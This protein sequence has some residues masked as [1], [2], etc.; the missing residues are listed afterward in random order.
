MST[1]FKSIVV[2]A[3][4]YLLISF[5]FSTF[6]LKCYAQGDFEKPPIDYLNAPVNDSVHRL[7]ELTQ[8]GEL[9]LD[10]D[11]EF[12]YLK[13]V[14][15][16]LDVPESSQTLV[17]SKTSLQL[18]RI[19]P[20]HPR[21]LYFN[22][23]VYVGY[24]QKGD[25]LELAAT[26][27]KQGAIFYTLS[28]DASDKP[29]LT[30]DRGGCLTCHASTRTQNVPG[31][32]VRS[33][34]PDAAGHPK[35][36]SGSF[37]I[38]HKSEFK[39]RWGGW[40][41]TGSH[42]SMRHMGNSVCRGEEHEFDRE[43]GANVSGLDGYFRTATY[44]TP[45][46]DIV[47]LMVLEH[48]TQMHNA[49]AAANYETRQAIHQSFQMNEL[50]ERPEGYLSD[51]AIRRINA[52]VD[53]VV[54]HLFFV[55]EFQLTDKVVGS[56]PFSDEFE[57]RGPKDLRGRSLREFDLTTRLFRY[58]CSYLIYSAAFDGLPDEARHRILDQMIE[59]LDGK[60]SSDRFA[61]LNDEVRANIRE[62][63]VDTKP[64]FAARASTSR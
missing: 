63:L 51:S 27:P 9:T 41:V 54:E 7:S 50:L 25:V 33:V 44:L 1:A 37:T 62:I 23:E 53:K 22:D 52:V 16:A 29:K 20:R 30:R 4:H 60:D 10:Y 48:Q 14:L 21:S 28:Q 42:G 17:F 12:G 24:C 39:D 13:S 26:D 46:S 18:H 64:E 15:K 34:F 3:S 6:G 32:L 45:H 55:D 58:P 11:E 57:S 47:A 31:Y 56:S 49:I 35:L 38:D 59:V 40:Y 61:H 2:K 43:Q 19:S 8:S 36:G 5:V